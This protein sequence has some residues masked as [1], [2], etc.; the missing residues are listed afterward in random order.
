MT[1]DQVDQLDPAR[2]QQWR[3][4]LQLL[5]WVTAGII[6]AAALFMAAALLSGRR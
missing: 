4:T 5:G 6:L 3:D 1:Q 2:V